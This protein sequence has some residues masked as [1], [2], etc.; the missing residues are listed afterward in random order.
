[1]CRVLQL[2]KRATVSSGKATTQTGARHARS[3][4]VVAAAKP[5]AAAPAASTTRRS[6]VIRAAGALAAGAA[7][8]VPAQG[9]KAFLGLGEDPAVKYTELTQKMIDDIRAALELP[10][11]TD[12]REAAMSGV[13]KQTVAWVSAYRRD[14]KFAGRPSFSQM[15][16]AVNALDGQLVSFG[17]KANFPAKRLER[18]MKSID[19]AERAL[20]R[21]R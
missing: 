9:A 12:E 15:Y 20:K 11:N 13:K 2:T 3:L 5:E 4:V 10:A 14:P 1:L 17:L 8:F 19:D 16:S 6:A 7:F 21:G 18:M